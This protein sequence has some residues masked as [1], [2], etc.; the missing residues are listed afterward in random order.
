MQRKVQ[1]K[2]VEVDPAPPQLLPNLPVGIL[3]E[4]AFV[5]EAVFKRQ[6]YSKARLFDI[7]ARSVLFQGVK[8]AN[9][10]LIGAKLGALQITDAHFLDCDLRN[11]V[12]DNGSISR[13]LLESSCL[14]GVQFGDAILK[15]VTFKN[16]KLDLANF[17]YAT[18]LNVH[19]LD[20]A[21]EQ[22][23]WDSTKFEKVRLENCVLA[24]S[25]FHQCQ[26]QHLD[27]R[28]SQLAGINGIAFLKRVIIDLDQATEIAPILAKALG[29][30]MRD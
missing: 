9:C 11:M 21:L 1:K 2:E 28:S 24:G 4:T 5:N 29:L 25:V 16:C 26:I 13:T 17:S 8:L 14:S 7:E 23:D 10:S 27:L 20:C 6:E 15:D 3:D 19:F 30:I 18:L 12:A 22:S